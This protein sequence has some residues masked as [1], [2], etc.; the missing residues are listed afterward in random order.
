MFKI[1][2]TLLLGIAIG[3]LIAPD[4]GSKTREKLADKVLGYIDEVGAFIGE[5]ANKLNSKLNA[6]ESVMDTN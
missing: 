6:V 5:K 2:N 1:T 4:K 3:I